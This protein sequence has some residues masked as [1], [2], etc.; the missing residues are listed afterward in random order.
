MDA[1]QYSSQR[2]LPQLAIKLIML[3]GYED[4]YDISCISMNFWRKHMI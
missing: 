1:K 4:L 3:S 2:R